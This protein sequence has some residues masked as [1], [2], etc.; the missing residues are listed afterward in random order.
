MSTWL[1]VVPVAGILVRSLLVTSIAVLAVLLPDE[2]RA[3][4]AERVLRVL[5]RRRRIWQVLALMLRHRGAQCLEDAGTPWWAALMRLCWH[6]HG[7]PNTAAVYR[8]C[9]HGC[10]HCR[11]WLGA[12]DRV[13]LCTATTDH[14][15]P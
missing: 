3:Q 9:R 5:L 13:R 2:K 6:R 4:R 7:P 8:R 14:R 12:A 10:R 1:W 15:R 11:R